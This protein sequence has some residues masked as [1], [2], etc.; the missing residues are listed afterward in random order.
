[1]L[2]NGVKLREIAEL[3]QR[4]AVLEERARDNEEEPRKRR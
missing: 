2:E 4:I 1:V 3:E